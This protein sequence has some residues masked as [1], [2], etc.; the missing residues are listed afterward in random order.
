MT[1]RVWSTAA[2]V[3]LAL[4]LAAPAA[5]AQDIKLKLSHFVPPAHNHHAN[6]LVPGAWR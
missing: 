5:S 6:V 4:A 3:L 2:V 1:H